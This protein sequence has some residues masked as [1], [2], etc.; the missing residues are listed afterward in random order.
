MLNPSSDE[1][2]LISFEAGLEP[3]NVKP[4]FENP[5]ADIDR[6]KSKNWF[7]RVLPIL[8]A[9]RWSFIMGITLMIS[10]MMLGVS[11]PALIGKLVDS[12]EPTLTTGEISN[13]LFLVTVILIISFVRFIGGAIGSYQ[14]GRVSNQL[15]A[16]LR[17]VIYNHLFT[18][19]FSFF[20]KTQTG[21]LISRANSDIKTIQ[22]FLMIAPMLLTSLL[23]FAFAAVYMLSVH[24]TLALA[25]M[26]AIPLVFILSVKL[27]RL[28]FPLSWL[29]QAR[30]A[31]VA[32]IVDENINGQ[33]IVK[34]FA[35][36][37]M[38]VNLLAI[39]AKKLQWVQVRSIDVSAFY[40]PLIENLSVLG[41]V[42]VWVYGG[43]LVIEGEIGL[44]AL[45]AFTM[46]LMMIQMPFRFLGW[47]L[48]LE[49]RAKASAGRIFEILDETSEIKDKENKVEMEKL[50]GKISFNDVHFAY[51]EEPILKGLSFEVEPKETV[52]IVGQT[53]SG[54]STIVRLLSRFYEAD[55]GNISI[56]GVPVQ[57]MGIRNLHYHIAQVLDEP[58]LFSVSIKDNIAYGRPDATMD[59]IIQAAKA[60]EAHDFINQTS[61]GYE[62][63]VGERGYTLSG[64]QRQRLGI[65]RALLVDPSILILDDATS[66]ID[67][68]IE[69]MIHKSLLKLLDKRTTILIAHRLSTISLAD[70]VL[71]LD[72]GKIIASGTHE[73]LLRDEPRYSEILAQQST[74]ETPEE[75]QGEE[76]SD[77][78]YR[79]RISETLIKDPSEDEF[80]GGFDESGS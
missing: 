51:A 6:D 41:S 79:K 12:I 64:G 72:N 19:S 37:L 22:M 68:K 55:K 2:E 43:W 32:V 70:R 27:R 56:D 26:I 47:M 57:D 23:S 16:D 48:M 33:R 66:S 45:V 36:E 30:Q 44:G 63:V 8:M 9:N 65:A 14:L 69:A 21:Q 24:L 46:Y 7:R 28:T 75:E 13:F 20:D 10:T 5:K 40:N 62:T 80:K 38:Q 77:E 25:S 50:E 78:E 39:A 67:V 3:V 34:S 76:E 31:D 17:S 71:V 74:T 29:T 53:G 49:Q 4:R 11:V 58:F 1:L 54:K 35:Q 61:D 73:D 15:E 60:A 42:F 52:A 59:E 18:L